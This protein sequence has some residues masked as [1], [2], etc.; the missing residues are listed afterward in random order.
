MEAIAVAS[1]LSRFLGCLKSE[2]RITKCE[3]ILNPNAPNSKT[4]DV[5]AF[6][7]CGL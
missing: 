4:A 5:T 6:Q 2:A 1:E 3:K 7:N